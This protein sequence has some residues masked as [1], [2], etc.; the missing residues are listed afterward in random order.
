MAEEVKK[1]VRL[2]NGHKLVVKNAIKKAR[3]ILTPPGR[4]VDEE[5]AIML[6]SFQTT[7]QNKQED[8]KIIDNDILE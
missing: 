2:K 6:E 3:D 7:M 4:N 8:I 5:T 1:K